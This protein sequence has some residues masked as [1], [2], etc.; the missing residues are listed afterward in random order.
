MASELTAGY[1]SFS[2]LQL[3]RI[4]GVPILN[5]KHLCHVLDKLTQPHIKNENSIKVNSDVTNLNVA[6]K[7]TL[8][9]RGAVDEVNLSGRNSPNLDE[10]NGVT[11]SQRE[12]DSYTSFE[13]LN[14]DT[15]EER[16]INADCISGAKEIKKL[17][18]HE[19]DRL[20][21][22]F[23]RQTQNLYYGAGDDPLLL[24]CTNFIHLELDKDKV[25][26]FDIASAY[27]QNAEILSQ[28]AI[29]SSRSDNLP[30]QQ[31]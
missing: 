24:D 22:E 2:N 21:S 28:Y 15:V 4:N 31:Y 14:E 25:I 27:I 23:T 7:L 20:Y 8:Q 18:P 26:V 11:V 13:V 1:D 30:K 29:S 16:E 19:D 5:L 6:E 12:K 3:Y 17:T 10:S 9:I